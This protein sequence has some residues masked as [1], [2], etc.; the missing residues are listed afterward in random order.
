MQEVKEEEFPSYLK[1]VMKRLVKDSGNNLMAIYTKQP[2]HKT[3]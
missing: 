1:K 2:P 3:H